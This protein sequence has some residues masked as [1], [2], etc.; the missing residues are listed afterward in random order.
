MSYVLEA[1]E[2]PIEQKYWSCFKKF[3]IRLYWNL[4]YIF[5]C[6]T[7]SVW[8]FLNHPHCSLK[9]RSNKLNI[10]PYGAII[11][12]HRLLSISENT[13]VI[14]VEKNKGT[15]TLPWGVPFSTEGHPHFNLDVPLKSKVSILAIQ[16]LYN[17]II[18]PSFHTI[19]YV[20]STLLIL[21]YLDFPYFSFEANCWGPGF[22]VACCLIPPAGG[23]EEPVIVHRWRCR[24]RHL[25]AIFH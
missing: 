12:K 20:S 18:N 25:H 24:W 1:I 14:T 13:P 11:C 21:F 16:L 15:I 8:P 6:K 9:L 23:V 7:P 3:F 5:S 2:A 19:S 10:L 17:L 4:C 22:G